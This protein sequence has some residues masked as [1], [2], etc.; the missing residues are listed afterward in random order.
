MLARR[1]ATPL[2][3]YRVSYPFR[4]RIGIFM[5]IRSLASVLLVFA[6]VVPPGYSQQ[7][8]APQT[9]QSASVSI[10]KDFQGG[11]QAA[12]EATKELGLVDDP[13]VTKRVNDIGYRVAQRASPDR[14]YYSFRVVKMEEPNA[15]ALPGGFIFVTTGMMDLG[16]TDD[17]LAALL[18]HEITHVK[19][20][21]SK[22]MAKRQTLMNLLYS[23]LV[24]GVAVGLKGDNSGYDPV[25]GGYRTSQKAEVLQGAQ[26]FGILF[27][28]LLLR[29]FSRDLELEADHEGMIAAA[30]AGFSPH[31]TEQLFDKMRKKLYEAPGYGYLRTHPYL[32]DRSE[33]ARVQAANLEP[34]KNPADD[35]DFRNQCQQTFMKYM[36][37]E[38]D[39]DGKLELRRM[40][41]RAM[42]VGKTA[43]DLRW[44]FI[45]QAES[46]SSKKESFYRDYGKLAKL[47]QDNIDD[48]KGDPS[49]TEFSTKVQRDLEKLDKDK[50]AVGPL[51]DEVLAKGLFDTEMLQRYLSNFPA[52]PRSPEIQFRLAENYRLLHKYPDAADLYLKVLNTQEDSEWKQQSKDSLLHM[53][54]NLTDLTACYRIATN[55]VDPALAAAATS[56]MKSLTGSFVSLQNGYDFRRAYPGSDYEKT[57][58]DRMSSLATD[59]VHQGKLYQAIGEYQKAL[60]EYNQVLRYCSDLPVADQVKDQ[61]I[62]FQEIT[63]DKNQG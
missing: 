46:E 28:E 14:P 59:V 47:Y 34:A 35:T 40:A 11:L 56:R 37:Q 41:L 58:T 48:V 6:L 19:N 62:D 9:Q 2:R 63:S 22:K 45:H 10:P 23:A 26:A 8:T 13:A 1:P 61:V 7:Q 50:V 24:V 30:R 31:G 54:S 15:F 49:S 51:Y 42:P 33:I 21:H 12:L 53:V 18:G 27:Q 16:L 36:P 38:K 20:D 57:V 60:D 3:G 25:T 32:E 29:G 17:E 5:K 43:E 4:I 44:F 52:S 55:N 39:E